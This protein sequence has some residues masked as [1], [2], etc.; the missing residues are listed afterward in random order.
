MDHL[1][2]YV[3]EV[4]D[5]FYIVNYCL[6]WLITSWTYSITYSNNKKMVEVRLKIAITVCSKTLV[7]VS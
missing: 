5:P 3:Q 2:Q 1:V 4:S 6:K 7:Q